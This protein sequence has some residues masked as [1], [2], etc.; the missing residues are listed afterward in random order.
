MQTAGCREE[1]KE[2][3]VWRVSSRRIDRQSGLVGWPLS[4]H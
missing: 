2:D 1:A 4:G 3:S